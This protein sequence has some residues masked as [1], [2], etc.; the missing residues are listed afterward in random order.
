GVA[1]GFGLDQVLQKQIIAKMPGQE[2]VVGRMIGFANTFL[3]N[4]QSGIIAGVGILILVWTVLKVLNNI[5]QSFNDIWGIK[6]GRGFARQFSDYLAMLLICP[7]FV[8]VSGSMTVLV[9]SQFNL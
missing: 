5:E 3:E 6:K 8:V 4:T 2:E 7:F 9:T 1:K